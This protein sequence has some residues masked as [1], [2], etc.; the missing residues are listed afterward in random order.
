MKAVFKYAL[1]VADEQKLTL[2]AN[3]EILSVANQNENIVLYAL[4]D[5]TVRELR[6]HTIYIYGTGHV[7]CGED[8]AFIG[9]VV[10]HS[11]RLMFHV[12]RAVYPGEYRLNIR[13]DSLDGNLLGYC[14]E[15]NLELMQE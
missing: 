11:G 5:T 13:V 8:I 12:F 4:V 14:Q 6:N 7:V 10:L 3:A 9:T 15:E 1:K 2:P